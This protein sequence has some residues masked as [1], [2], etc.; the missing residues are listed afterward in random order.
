V[1]VSNGSLIEDWHCCIKQMTV[2]SIENQ[3]HRLIDG[4]GGYWQSYG[5]QGKVENVHIFHSQYAAQVS[6]SE[7]HSFLCSR[8]SPFGQLLV[9]FS[10]ICIQLHKLH[11]YLWIL[12]ILALGEIGSPNGYIDQPILHES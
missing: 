11:V 10:L 2:S 5:P 9:F 12:F 6:S 8:A 3:A 1:P 4:R 7:P